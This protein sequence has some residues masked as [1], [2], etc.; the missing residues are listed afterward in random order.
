MIKSGGKLKN[1]KKKVHKTRK[2]KQ[3]NPIDKKI[4]PEVKMQ[5]EE[6]EKMKFES[7]FFCE[8]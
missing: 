4:K 6:K 5:V 1:S 7:F 2:T 8:I 3:P